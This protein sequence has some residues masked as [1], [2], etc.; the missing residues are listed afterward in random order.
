MKVLFVCLIIIFAIPLAFATDAEYDENAHNFLF[1]S[2]LIIG[3]YYESNITYYGKAIIASN[4]D[5]LK[6]TKYINNSKITGTGKIEHAIFADAPVLRMNFTKYKQPQEQTCLF[7]SDLDNYARI[8][9]Y[10]YLPR[11]DTND[12]GLEAWFIDRSKY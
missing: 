1:G 9:C 2:Y 8:S 10:A 5:N 12:P 6:I 7:R 3:K 4:G 11:S